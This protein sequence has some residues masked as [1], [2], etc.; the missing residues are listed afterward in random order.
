MFGEN[1]WVGLQCRS[2][3]RATAHKKSWARSLT[4]QLKTALQQLYWVLHNTKEACLLH[5]PSCFN[6]SIMSKPILSSSLLEW[7]EPKFAQWHSENVSKFCNFISNPQQFCDTHLWHY[8]RLCWL[9]SSLHVLYDS[10]CFGVV[11]LSWH[12]CCTCEAN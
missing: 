10:L 1:Y 4:S 11:C 7:K 3:L 12:V 5:S 6:M 9:K 2:S 8:I